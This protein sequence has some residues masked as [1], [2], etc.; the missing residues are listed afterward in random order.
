MSNPS[1]LY[2]LLQEFVDST[3]KLYQADLQAVD[4]VG[5]SDETRKLI[6]HW[7]EEQTESE[8]RMFL[9]KYI[10]F[11]KAQCSST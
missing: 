9:E 10:C 5:A 8:K 4:F 11:Q 2:F 3:R 7:V 6:N 1:G